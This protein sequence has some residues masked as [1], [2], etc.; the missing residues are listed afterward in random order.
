MEI[1]TIEQTN[2]EH[3]F[4]HLNPIFYCLHSNFTLHGFTSLEVDALAQN[5]STV[6]GRSNLKNDKE[7]LKNFS[8]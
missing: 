8:N 5:S 4:K 1:Y 7:T 3:I 2:I 6:N